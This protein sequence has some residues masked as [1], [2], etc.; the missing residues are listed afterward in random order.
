MNAPS[1]AAVEDA[2]RVLAFQSRRVPTVQTYRGAITSIDDQRARALGAF[3]LVTRRLQRLKRPLTLDELSTVSEA[4]GLFFA[5]HRREAW[6]VYTQHPQRPLI[7]WKWPSL[8]PLL[9]RLCQ[10]T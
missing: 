4:A 9:W 5:Q 7:D 3:A 1:A 8:S 2:T 10:E 6:R